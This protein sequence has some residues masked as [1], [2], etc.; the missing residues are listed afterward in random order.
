MSDLPEARMRVRAVLGPWHK[1]A[2]LRLF[3]EH[4][5]TAQVAADALGVE[6]GRIA[7]SI[8]MFAGD[9]PILVVT[10]GDR[11]VDRRKVKSILGGAKV[12]PASAEEVF[13]VTGF[14]AGGVSPVGL[15]QVITTLLDTSLQRFS[16]VWA[17][18]G[19]PEALLML[20]VADLPLMTG[21]EFA[22]VGMAVKPPDHHSEG[23]S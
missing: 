7:K 15:Q 11:R 18:G 10:S 21:G 12:R 19:V 23:V 1:E 2:N 4:L 20:S 9:T 22:D 6:L 3:E 5:P 8:V 13:A 14:V 17:G 16:D